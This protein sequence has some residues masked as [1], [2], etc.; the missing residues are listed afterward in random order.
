MQST[1][2]AHLNEPG[3]FARRGQWKPTKYSNIAAAMQVPVLSESQS[4]GIVQSRHHIGRYSVWYERIYNNMARIQNT[5][6]ADT[7]S[8]R[9]STD[10]TL[11]LQAS[12]PGIISDSQP[13]PKWR[14]FGR[15]CLWHCFTLH[16]SRKCMQS[17]NSHARVFSAA[18][19]HGRKQQYFFLT[20]PLPTLTSSIPVSTPCFALSFNPLLPPTLFYTTHFRKVAPVK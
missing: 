2:A 1:G 6:T 11:Y 10:W 16:S 5:E 9:P 20:L 17:T 15:Q 4:T 18:I 12:V 13:V 7:N 14:A 8:K 3:V 19:K